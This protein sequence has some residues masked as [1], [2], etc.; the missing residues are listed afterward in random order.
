MF[1][2]YIYIYLVYRGCVVPKLRTQAQSQ[3]LQHINIKH[4]ETIDTTTAPRL[5]AVLAKLKIQHAT[6]DRIFILIAFVLYKRT[7][8]SP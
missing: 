2:V 1:Y 3:I 4:I 6:P 7:A 8:K 5:S